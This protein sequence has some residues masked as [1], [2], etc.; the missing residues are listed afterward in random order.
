M[1]VGSPVV[2]F[3]TT[4]DWHELHRLL[5]AAFP[6]DVRAENALHEMQFGYVERPTHRSRGFDQQRFEVCN[7]RYT[8]LHDNSHGCA[9]LND[10]KYGVGVEE[11]SIEL[12]LLRA[13]ASPEMGSDQGEQRFR[14]GFTAWEGAFDRSPVVRQG[15]AFNLPVTVTPGLCEGFS[16]FATDAPNVII[17]TLKPADDGSGDMILRLYESQKADVIFRLR[18]GLP[19]KALQ[20]CDMLETPAGDFLAPDAALHARPFQ[21]LT[22]RVK[23]ADGRA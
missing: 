10:C 17:D 14:Y 6:V 11:N 15:L 18:S 9:V 23:L 5:K 3:D 16:A 13:A 19:V 8:A 2:T 22:L 4:V 7:H 21:V 20:L 1:Q 12:T